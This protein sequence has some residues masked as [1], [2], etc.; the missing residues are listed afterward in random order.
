MNGPGVVAAV[1]EGEF[2]D[3]TTDERGGGQ[4]VL[5]T[6]VVLFPQGVETLSFACGAVVGCP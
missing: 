1:P 6:S 3:A 4:S 2:L 5:K